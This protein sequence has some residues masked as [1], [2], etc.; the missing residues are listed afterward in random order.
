MRKP[1]A[2]EKGAVVPISPHNDL[3]LRLI[4]HMCGRE[5]FDCATID[6][7]KNQNTGSRAAVMNHFASGQLPAGA[8]VSNLGSVH[9]LGL[10]GA[11]HNDRGTIR[12][13][14]A[15]FS[16]AP[17]HNSGAA[18]GGP[19]EF[20]LRPIDAWDDLFERMA[21]PSE[22]TIRTGAAGLI[23]P[24][25]SQGEGAWM[26]R[27]KGEWTFVSNVQTARSGVEDRGHFAKRIED[28]SVFVEQTTV[29]FR[30]ADWALHAPKLFQ[31]LRH[32]LMK[33]AAWFCRTKTPSTPQF[34]V[35]D[36]LDPQASHHLKP[37]LWDDSVS[38][39][40]MD[41][42]EIAPSASPVLF[43][44]NELEPNERARRSLAVG[45]TRRVPG[46]S[47]QLFEPGM[48]SF[49]QALRA[50][51]FPVPADD[52]NL[53]LFR[54]TLAAQQF[55][56]PD[57]S[58]RQLL[59]QVISVQPQMAAAAAPALEILERLPDM[60][61][62]QLIDLPD[63][64]LISTIL[65]L[66]CA[67]GLSFENRNLLRPIHELYRGALLA[68]FRRNIFVDLS[69]LEVTS[70]LEF[71]PALMSAFPQKERGFD[72]DMVLGNMAVVRELAPATYNRLCQRMDLPSDGLYRDWEHVM[73]SSHS[74]QA[75][76]RC[77]SA[78][79]RLNHKRI[80]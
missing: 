52:S 26:V 11:E 54:N 47:L 25:A 76:G 1:I 14:T 17:S 70:W 27:H 43:L 13:E 37:S 42:N 63:K 59:D 34:T 67:Y 44:L 28:R 3:F 73:K 36:N 45:F 9:S 74:R 30:R 20:L 29:R 32:W 46:I 65:L 38:S 49:G 40:L 75:F 5:N 57:H 78:F 24:S 21:R 6:E 56:M 48:I 15:F 50:A 7:T 68:L 61:R 12:S 62:G 71:A 66:D 51:D 60:N 16:R 2:L 80:A 19:L 18:L 41:E 58:A 77:L 55:E 79:D 10:K 8:P 64:S 35:N 23:A 33:E 53:N 69:L 4:L 72:G 31:E 39:I 22:M